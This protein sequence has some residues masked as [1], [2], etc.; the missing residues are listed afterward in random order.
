MHRRVV[1]EREH[2]VENDVCTSTRVQSV[3]AYTS[4]RARVGV[5]SVYT[6]LSVNEMVLL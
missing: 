1:W 3:C 2:I 6:C 4:I 5:C